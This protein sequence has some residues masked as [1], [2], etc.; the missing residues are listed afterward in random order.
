MATTTTPERGAA[1]RRPTL[2]LVAQAVG[3][4]G[5]ILCVV[6]IVGL[7]VGRGM[8]TERVDEL[9]TRADAAVARGVELAET[10]AQGFEARADEM[11]Q[12]VADAQAIADDPTASSAVLQGLVARLQPLS[13]RYAQVR[14]TY[15]GLK[16]RVTTAWDFLTTIDRLLPGFALPPTSGERLASIDERL[17]NLD[18]AIT[19]ILTASRATTQVSESAAT[20]AAMATRLETGLDE[21]T[22]L[23][24]EVEADLEDLQGRVAQAADDLE[25]LLGLAILAATAF[26]IYLALLH[27][28]LWALGRRWRRA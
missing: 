26:L 4:V 23:A 7:W 6:L 18:S 19:D 20:V 22:A 21:A 27:V 5:T 3:V 2:G 16:E 15:A 12:V 28:A 11:G 9:A 17:T 13:D 10:V 1:P 8:V 24:R 14:D 25:D